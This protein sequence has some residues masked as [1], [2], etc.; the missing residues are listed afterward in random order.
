MDIIFFVKLLVLLNTPLKIF[1]N[2]LNKIYSSM[3]L[4]ISLTLV[5]IFLLKLTEFSKV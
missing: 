1:Y 3:L 5:K 2:L 4:V